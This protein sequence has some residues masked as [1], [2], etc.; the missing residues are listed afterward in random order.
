MMMTRK[1][2]EPTLE[3]LGSRIR[4]RRKRL[5]LSQEELGGRLTMDAYQIGRIERGLRDPSVLLLHRLAAALDCEVAA[6]L[7]DGLS[8]S[9]NPSP[10]SPS[11]PP[12]SPPMAEAPEDPHDA[13][14]ASHRQ[15]IRPEEVR[16]FR[17]ERRLSQ[18]RLGQLCGVAQSTVF[19]WEAGEPPSGPAAI[20]LRQLL[21]PETTKAGDGNGSG[22]PVPTLTAA[23]DRLFNELIQRGNFPSRQDYL[24]A[25]LTQL[26]LQGAAETSS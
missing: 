22:N 19:R 1:S 13:E 14:E 17:R 10:S 4:E 3:T 12:L 21:T 5:R 18:Q 7:G 9:P 16:R 20:V 23:E 8:A 15:I 2:F 25:A 11:S 6:L 26:I 24:A